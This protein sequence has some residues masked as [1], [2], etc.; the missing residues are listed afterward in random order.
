MDN[1]Q[2]GVRVYTPDMQ[3]VSQCK[4][5]LGGAPNNEN[6]RFSLAINYLQTTKI[7]RIY[8]VYMCKFSKIFVS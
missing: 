5:P 2:D 8:S 1:K 7:I 3:R 4:Q 6:N